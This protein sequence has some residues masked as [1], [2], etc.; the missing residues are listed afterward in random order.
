[1]RGFVV[2]KYFMPAISYIFDVDEKDIKNI[3]G[4]DFSN[5]KMFKRT[6]IADLQ[7]SKYRIEIQSGY[8]NVN[9][10]KQHKIK[11]A[12]S[13]LEPT[14]LIHFDIYNGQVAFIRYSL[15]NETTNGRANSI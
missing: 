8:Q 9:D 2:T 12:K 3:G 7:I 4:D 6:P 10:I 5:E 13:K 15:G 1:M 11:E 14:I